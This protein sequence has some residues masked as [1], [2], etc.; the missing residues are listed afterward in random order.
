MLE[1]QQVVFG[2][3]HQV[4]PVA[5]PPQEAARRVHVGQAGLRHDALDDQVAQVGELELDLGQPPGR[6]QVAQ[7]AAA[8]LD[9]GL[10]QIQR[11]AVLPVAGAALP[12]L[13]LEE[14]GAALADH[15]AGDR[16]AKLLG[17]GRIP[18]DEPAVEQRGADFEVA[19][20]VPQTLAD[21]PHR[22]ADLPARVHQAVVQALPDRLRVWRDLPVVQEQQVDVRVRAQFPAPVAAQCEDAAALVQAHVAARVQAGRRGEDVFHET[23]HERRM[24]MHDVPSAVPAGVPLGQRPP[25]FFPVTFGDPA[26]VPVGVDGRLG[27]RGG[28]RRQLRQRRVGRRGSGRHGG[29]GRVRAGLQGAQPLPVLADEL[30]HALEDALGNRLAVVRGA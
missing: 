23:V 30:R 20:G 27:I 13:G 10:Q 1:A 16:G 7:P 6:M 18:A 12:G 11:V 15:V 28:E 21:V 24:Q 17:Q 4:E 29:L 22:V 9:V 5:D 26:Q 2:A 25:D 3:L 8:V 14:R 19:V